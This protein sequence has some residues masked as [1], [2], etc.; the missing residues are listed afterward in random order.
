MSNGIIKN[1]TWLTVGNAVTKPVWLWFTIVLLAGSLGE[2]SYGVLNAALALMLVAG[3]LTNLGAGNYIVRE[4]ARRKEHAGAFFSNFFLLQLASVIVVL[5]AAIGVG[6]QIGYRDTKLTALFFAGIYAMSAAL[7]M[8]CRAFFRA[9]EQ[10]RWVSVSQIAEKGL[11]V[12]FGTALLL[13]RPSPQAALAGMATGMILTLLGNVVFVARRV[14]SFDVSALHFDFLRTHVTRALPLGL[15][16]FFTA[17]YFRTDQVMVEAIAGEASN[18][19]Y[20]MAYRII[21]ATLILPLLLTE[22][23]YPRL[24]SLYHSLDGQKFKSLLQRGLSGVIVFAL[25]GAVALFLL[26]GPI[27]ELI[28]LLASSTDY[29]GVPGPLRVLAWTLPFMG[30]NGLLCMVLT[31]QDDQRILAIGFGIA[32]LVNVGMNLTLI[33]AVGSMGAAI[34]TLVTEALVTLGLVAR[35]LTRTSR[36][37]VPEA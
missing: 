8:L 33:P 28:Q 10:M 24:S 18:G 5:A 26:A 29:V 31:A 30:V 16:G 35:Y 25:V 3:G 27:V 17:I 6:I 34:A 20:S 19:Q 12:G 23:L 37:S 15:I 21:E 4:V 14:A 9:F 22:V 7:T 11:V 13:W 1:L 2:A 36:L 32:A